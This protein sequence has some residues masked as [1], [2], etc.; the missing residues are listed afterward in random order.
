MDMPS[1]VEVPRPISSRISRLF[2]VAQ[3][4]SSDTSVISTMKVDCPAARSSLAP[5]RVKMRSTTPMCA[6][7]AGT[8]LPTCAMRVMSATWRI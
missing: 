2:F 8:K 6:R 1:K 3:R 7:C 4:R 5:M